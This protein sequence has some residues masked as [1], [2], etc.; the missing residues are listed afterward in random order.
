LRDN[1]SK[2][3]YELKVVDEGQGRVTIEGFPS[4]KKDAWL[5]CL[6]EFTPENIK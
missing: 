5:S 2:K 1:N 3:E 4:E 6:T